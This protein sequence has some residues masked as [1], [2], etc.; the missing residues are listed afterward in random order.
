MD[1]LAPLI[2]ALHREGRLRVWSLVITVFGDLVQHRGGEISTARLGQL[3]GR[4]GVEQG[5]LR[6][7]LSRLGRDGWVTRERDGRTSLYRLSGQG[8]ERFAPATTRIY[9]APRKGP[10]TRWTIVVRL[11]A[12]GTPETTLLPAD[13][14]CPDADCRVTGTLDRISEAYRATLLGD[15]HR[16]A[17][18][19]LERD[20]TALANA[21]T[22]DPL[23]A[24][25]ARMLLIHRWRRIVLRYPDLPADL[26]PKDTPL[27]DPRSAVAQVYARLAPGAEAWLDEGLNGLAP[28]PPAPTQIGQ[29]FGG[30]QQG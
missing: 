1:P 4:V 21:P 23:D 28:M 7:A 26:M 9:A 20:L 14:A 13:D 8:L 5:T 12:N 2:T 15:P 17:L 19:S 3:L 10:V 6:T 18:V 11:G 29:R 24:A 22:L 16:A 30:L 25:A 27:A